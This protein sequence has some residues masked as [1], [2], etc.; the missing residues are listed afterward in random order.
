MELSH[1]EIQ[2]RISFTS[3]L[4]GEKAEN[5]GPDIRQKAIKPGMLSCCQRHPLES[6]L[7]LRSS[8]SF[9][10]SVDDDDRFMRAALSIK[11]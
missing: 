3:M 7:L 1:D 9:E 4:F 8:R 2:S 10:S 5:L 6:F 11:H